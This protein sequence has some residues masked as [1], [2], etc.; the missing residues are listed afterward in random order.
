MRLRSTARETVAT[1]NRGGTEGK[2]GSH[3]YLL[4]IDTQASFCPILGC[5][6]SRMIGKPANCAEHKRKS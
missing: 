4:P 6:V 3:R 2:A 1:I 5:D